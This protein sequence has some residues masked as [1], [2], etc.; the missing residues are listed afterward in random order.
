MRKGSL[1]QL[2]LA[3]IQGKIFQLLNNKSMDEIAQVL[4]CRFE[5][6]FIQNL[7]LFDQEALRKFS[8]LPS[9]PN[10]PSKGYLCHLREA[11]NLSQKQIGKVLNIS[12]NLISY[13][14]KMEAKEEIFSK[15]ANKV[16]QALN[17]EIKY[18]LV[19]KKSNI[20]K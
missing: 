12:K 2:E 3:E 8:F 16:L 10:I 6:A 7:P 14:E 20:K 9:Y 5:Y 4:N 13:S 17:C 11:L 19:S 1:Q 15:H 18:I